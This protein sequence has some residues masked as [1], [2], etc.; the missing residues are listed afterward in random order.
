MDIS[1]KN[2][3]EQ[4]PQELVRSLELVSAR[5]LDS[6]V[7]VSQLASASTPEMQNLFTQWVTMTGGELLRIAG[8][9]GTIDPAAAADQIGITPE[10]ALSLALT[11][12]RQG[13][14]KIT[15]L[16][17]EPGDGRNKDIC[18]CMS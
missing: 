11:L 8:D 1:A 14:L 10:S 3:K 7:T 18:G 12:H 5:I 2:L 17:V 9:E 6:I 15:G 16:T 4:T 13:K